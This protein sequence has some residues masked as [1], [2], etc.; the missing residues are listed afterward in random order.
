MKYSL[1]TLSEVTSGKIYGNPE[2]II[3]KILIDSR[4]V[5]TDNNSLFIAI[6]GEHN[7]GHDYISIMYERN[8][9]TFLV[10]YLPEKFELLENTSF[11]LVKNALNALQQIASYNRK[12]YNYPILG[13][14]GSNGKTII[15]EWIF[16]LLDDK[17]KIIRNP[18][19]TF[20][21]KKL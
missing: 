20:T 18:K 7:D 9:R 16:Q 13:I 4:T 8:I 17:K 2:T 19:S 10:E 6:K 1:E 5:V 12:Q 15:K 3:S 14:T 21:R 11:L